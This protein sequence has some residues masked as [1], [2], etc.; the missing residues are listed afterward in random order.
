MRHSRRSSS[1]LT[2]VCRI[3]ERSSGPKLFYGGFEGSSHRRH[4]GRR[5]DLLAMTRH[6]ELVELGYR[7][8]SSCGIR[9][10]RNWLRWRW[11]ACQV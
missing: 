11:G 4:D 3:E 1:V 7:M 8:V 9:T 5:L 10:V 6:D 2:P